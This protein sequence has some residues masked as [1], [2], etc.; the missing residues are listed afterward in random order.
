MIVTVDIES[1]SSTIRRTVIGRRHQ[2]TVA[3]RSQFCVEGT[4]AT[5]I[6][7][8]TARLDRRST[9]SNLTSN[10]RGQVRVILK[11]VRRSGVTSTSLPV[12]LSNQLNNGAA[13][14]GY[15]TIKT[16]TSP[17]SPAVSSSHHSPGI[18]PTLIGKTEQILLHILQY[19]V[20]QIFT[21]YENLMTRYWLAL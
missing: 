11:P 1:H 3:G 16:H 20:K 8:S 5:K 9:A 10:V 2:A 14:T 13:P 19:S 6:V 15:V 21:F 7:S 4:V 18:T 17:I 12:P